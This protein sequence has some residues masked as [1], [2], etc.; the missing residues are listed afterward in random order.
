M[1]DLLRVYG[2]ATLAS[3]LL[4]VSEEVRVVRSVRM[5]KR[6]EEQLQQKDVQVAA[7]PGV[8]SLIPDLSGG[9]CKFEVKDPR[10][11]AEETARKCAKMCR[12]FGVDVP[13][14]PLALKPGCTVNCESV[15]ECKVRL[16]ASLNGS[17]ETATFQDLAVG[18]ALEDYRVLQGH[19]LIKDFLQNATHKAI[20]S[21]L[22]A[23]Q[24][25]DA[26]K[27]VQEKL[28]EWKDGFKDM[29]VEK[30]GKDEVFGDYAFL[31]GFVG[32]STELVEALVPLSS[33]ETSSGDGTQL[34]AQMEMPQAKTYAELR[35]SHTLENMS[36]LY[37]M[38]PAL[39]IG[40]LTA[41]KFPRL[42]LGI[43]ALGSGLIIGLTKIL[44]DSIGPELLGHTKVNVKAKLPEDAQGLG[45][46][47]SLGIRTW[48]NGT[49][50]FATVEAVPM[51]M[52]QTM[53]KNLALDA[54]ADP[55][56]VGKIPVKVVDAHFDLQA[57][58]HQI[59]VQ[60]S[61]YADVEATIDL[62]CMPNCPGP[63]GGIIRCG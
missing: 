45:A 31:H 29:L 27:L 4:Q 7:N 2:V 52:V 48:F 22:I 53:L 60:G 13:C 57:E 41:I 33:F 5:V 6:R 11:C 25:I 24:L 16:R 63:C 17:V 43:A 12:V 55:D 61:S 9:D 44:A 18:F 34:S 36:P 56:K 62:G 37:R 32:N 15:A 58:G 46:P 28:D 38:A 39:A 35:F 10:R 14:I 59:T 8:E 30:L 51:A 50:M 3:L 49:S 1:K 23:D 20:L 47:E 42:G 21:N 40:A 19:Q 54:T 26:R